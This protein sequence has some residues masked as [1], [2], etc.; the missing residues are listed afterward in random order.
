MDFPGIE[1]I[2]LDAPKLS[3]NDREMPE[4]VTERMFT[5]PS[6]LDTIAS[7][8]SAL[9]QDE[10]VGGSAPPVASEVEVEVL[11]ESASGTE[12]VVDVSPPSPSREG[13]GASQP[14]PAETNTAAPAASMVAWWRVL[15]EGRG[16]RH[17][18]RLLLPRR[19]SLCRASPS[20]LLKSATPLRA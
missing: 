9:R 18:D 6:T 10:G 13:T 20:R 8:A 4:V 1:A 2:N 5:D 17:P 7:V 14:Q 19:R 12:S 3:S 11:E 16:L 15:S